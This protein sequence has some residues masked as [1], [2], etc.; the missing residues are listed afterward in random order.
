MRHTLSV[1]RESWD[2]LC[3]CGARFASVGEPV[4]AQAAAHVREH[5]GRAGVRADRLAGIG[6]GSYTAEL[7]RKWYI[8]R[9]SAWR[10]LESLRR[11]GLVRKWRAQKDEGFRGRA[12]WSLVEREP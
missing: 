4:I 10:Y 5:S 8:T 6:H 2:M 12:E 9:S 3:T 1:D 7:A 11:H